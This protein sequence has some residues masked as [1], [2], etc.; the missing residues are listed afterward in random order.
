MREEL[1]CSQKRASLGL[2]PEL[3]GRN[4]PRNEPPLIGL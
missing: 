1:R 3:K 2:F 4:R